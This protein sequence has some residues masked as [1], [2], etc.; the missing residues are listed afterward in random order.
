[1]SVTLQRVRDLRAQIRACA[2]E[3]TSKR[4]LP[5]DIV[6]ALR[7]AG[8]FRM[9]MPTAWGGPE[10][11]IL[12]QIEVIEEASYANGSVGWCVMI[13]C[14]TGYYSAFLDDSVAR[15][16]FP[17]LD[18][19]TAGLA[20]PATSAVKVD[21][22]YRVSGRWRFGSGINHADHVVGGAI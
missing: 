2:T 4:T 20:Q 21:G 9:P 19:V 1:M 5:D 14:D 13:G 22:G 10:L 16:A 8:A 3:I 18:G 12:E 17:S 11:P 6:Q 15:E 7:D